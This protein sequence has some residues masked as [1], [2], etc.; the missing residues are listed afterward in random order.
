M[1]SSRAGARAHVMPGKMPDSAETVFRQNG[2]WEPDRRLTR[3]QATSQTSINFARSI[4]ADEAGRVHLVWRDEQDGNTEIWAFGLRKPWRFSFDEP[5]LGGT[6]ALL[7]GDVG[8][9]AR[10]EVDYQAAGVGGLNY[11]WRLREG[12]N[13]FDGRRAAAFDPLT[14]PIHD[15]DRSIGQSITGGFVYRGSALDPSFVGRY[16]YADFVAGRAFSF[17]L[18]QRTKGAPAMSDL[19]EHT[20]ALSALRGRARSGPTRPTSCTFSITRVARS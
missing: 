19:R 4:A 7:I 2:G 20:P 5:R 10:E 16:F 8:Q 9:N 12:R 13:A 18:N 11:G 1:A 15:Y 3:T 17:A 14:E 6:G